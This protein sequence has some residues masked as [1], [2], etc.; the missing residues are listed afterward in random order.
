MTYGTQVVLGTTCTYG[1]IVYLSEWN[2]TKL[3]WII[4]EVCDYHNTSFV[5]AHACRALMPRLQG[6]LASQLQN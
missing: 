3:I 6:S 4:P 1:N 5:C 2:E